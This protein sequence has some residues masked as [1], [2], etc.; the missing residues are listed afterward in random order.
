MSGSKNQDLQD[1]HQSVTG[2]FGVTP[3]LSM[4]NESLQIIGR[5]CLVVVH[6]IGMRG[7]GSTI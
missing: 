3:N 7:L 6:G 4:E 5:R 1:R 2:T